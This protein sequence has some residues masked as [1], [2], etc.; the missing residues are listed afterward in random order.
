MAGGPGLATQRTLQRRSTRRQLA[1]V[2]W[3]APGLKEW[4]QSGPRLNRRQPDPCAAIICSPSSAAGTSA[5]SL[6]R[7]RHGPDTGRHSAG[8][9]QGETSAAAS[10]LRLCDGHSLQ[11]RIPAPPAPHPCATGAGTYVLDIR[12]VV[13][14]RRTLARG[15]MNVFEGGQLLRPH[16]AT[17]AKVSIP[18]PGKDL[19]MTLVPST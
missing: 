15:R 9:L 13:W 16:C 5:A 18:W 8:A 3:R 2:A 14:A 1:L 10:V 12:G 4:R 19:A 6:L 7:M 17:S 11:H